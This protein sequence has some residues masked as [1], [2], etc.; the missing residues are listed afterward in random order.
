MKRL[1]SSI[2][3]LSLIFAS[4]SVFAD[5]GNANIG[6]VDKNSIQTILESAKDEVAN[7]INNLTKK[8]QDLKGHWAIAYIEPLFE[9]GVIKGYL[10][11]TFRPDNPIS[12]AEFTKILVTSLHEDVGIYKNGHWATNYLNKAIEEDYVLEGEF[13]D[14]NKNITRGEMARMIVRALDEDY[15]SNILAYAEQIIDYNDIPKEF[16]DF[17]LKAYVKGIITGYPDGTFKPENT[18]T[19]AEAS[20]MVVRFLEPEKREAPIS[21]KIIVDGKEVPIANT[22]IAYVYNT[23]L[24]VFE[25][26]GSR[27]IIE[28]ANFDDVAGIY[29]VP[30]KDSTMYE[31]IMRVGVWTDETEEG[32][33]AYFIEVK[34]HTD[35]TLGLTKEILKEIFPNGYEEIY[36]TFEDIIWTDKVVNGK[37]NG[38][39]YQ[40]KSMPSST[41]I[42]FGVKR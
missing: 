25:E 32:L 17:V 1:I 7:L 21:T 12:R 9:K 34:D 6:Q 29:Y 18:A 42:A 35:E 30:N 28:V 27:P 37:S 15:P 5:E 4:V 36:N 33:Y 10:D 2:L 13:D 11:G 24:K 40:L 8:F 31:Y 20:T 38:R 16:R 39:I 19:R 14:L 22:D 26:K 23:A 3:I 41:S